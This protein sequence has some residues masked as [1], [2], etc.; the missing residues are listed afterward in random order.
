[1]DTAQI[2]LN[3]VRSRTLTTRTLSRLLVSANAAPTITTW[4]RVP[5]AS[6]GRTHGAVTE[7]AVHAANDDST[8][9][10]R[11]SSVP[12]QGMTRRKS[13]SSNVPRNAIQHT[14][15]GFGIPWSKTAAMRVAVFRCA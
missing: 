7:S 6:S 10:D 4:A 3:G 9:F 11:L 2:L 12:Y 8:K 14:A 5:Q 1:M 13:R 15:N